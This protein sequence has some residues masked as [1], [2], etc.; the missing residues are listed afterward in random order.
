MK[1][2]NPQVGTAQLTAA[3]KIVNFLA[4]MLVEERVRREKARKA[5]EQARPARHALLTQAATCRRSTASEVKKRI[6]RSQPTS[7][8]ARRPKKCIPRRKGT[9]LNGVRQQARSQ[10]S[11]AT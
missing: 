2:I 5:G 9:S 3:E 11:G 10:D 1:I 4:D 7:S 6:R 8:S